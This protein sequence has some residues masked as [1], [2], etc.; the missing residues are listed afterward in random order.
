M[1]EQ[2]LAP[3]YDPAPVERKWYAFWM[4]QG[5]FQASPDSG[6]PPFTIVIPPPNITGILHI[7]HILNNTIQDILI[8]SKRMQGYEALWMPGTDHAGIATQVVVE[9]KLAEKGIKRVDI[10]RDKFVREVW[11]WREQ[12]GGTI[13][14]QLKRLGASC[15]WDKE[16]FT[17]DEGLSEAV[18]K[19]FVSLYEKGLIYRGYR[20]IN[21]C[22]R[23]HTAL[24]NEEAIP[25]EETGSL[26]VIKYPIKGE[27]SF[28]AIATTRPET[29]LGDTGVAVHPDDPRHG[30]LIGKSLI[31]P[32]NGREIPVVGD[33][34]LVD[35]EFGTGAVKVTPAHD[36][37]DF[38]M[39]QKHDLEQILIMD[40]GGLMNEAAGPAYSGLDR[41]EARKRVVSDLEELG[42]LVKVEPHTH[43][44]PHCQ[45]CDTVLEPY[46]SRQWFA[47][48]KPLA[49]RLLRALSH[50]GTPAFTPGHWIKTYRHWLENIEDWCISRQLWW[51]HRIPVWYCDDCDH[52]HV[53]AER[54]LA[55]PECGRHN[56]TQEEDVLDTWFSS[57]LWPFSTM[58]WPDNTRELS[59]FYP[60]SVLVTGHDILF[61]WVA[62]MMMMG[63]ECLDDRPFDDVYLT[64]L[65]RDAKGRKLSKSLGNSPDPIQVMDAYGSDGLRMAMM[66]MAPHGQ[67]I[68]YSE[69]RIETG[70][71]FANKVWNAARFVLMHQDVKLAPATSVADVSDRWDRWILH[72][73]GQTIESVTASLERYAFHEM[74]RA[75]YDFLWHDYCDWYL[76]VIK[77]RLFNKDNAETRD[78]ARRVSVS[79]MDQTLR[80]LH[81]IMPFITEEIWQ[82]LV[83][84]QIVV[85]KPVSIMV[86]D[87]PQMDDSLRD[88]TAEAEITLLQELT[89]AIREVRADFSVPPAKKMQVICHIH[90]TSQ[91]ELILGARSN[92][93]ALAGAEVL[94]SDSD[95]EGARPPLSAAGVLHGLEF[96]VPLADLIDLDVEIERLSKERDRVRQELKKVIARLSNEK[97]TGKA[98]A[99]V[100]DKERNKQSRY[101]DILERLERNLSVMQGVE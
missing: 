77:P 82:H 92:V 19:V 44:V 60:T 74:A 4:E 9:K 71:N 61:F 81:P 94:I 63:Y 62:R 18:L 89:G 80:L 59:Y 38:V 45:R 65:V 1:S 84:F 41:F 3:Q 21:W 57:A 47:R 95:E 42:L 35:P 11:K 27:D 7:G 50:D 52:M 79:V 23:C 90:Q 43:A 87:W 64:S 66:L 25:Q 72:R 55:C 31:L 53:S 70:R 13:I 30:H 48:M 17:M 69:D 5:L 22:P 58:G 97:F 93:E 16:R 100:V 32:L 28:L 34:D 36:P 2:G 101:E 86:S 98:P 51:G 24:S 76:E 96:Y 85:D 49:D 68:Y 12:Y 15:D 8:R 75:L 67:D 46:L 6:R 56:L 73:L 14:D 54:P 37:N 78:Q 10:G 33:A 91:K 26:W 83:D 40:E 99:D 88:P 29:M 20:I 39:G